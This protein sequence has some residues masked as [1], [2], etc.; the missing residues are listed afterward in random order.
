MGTMRQRDEDL[1]EHDATSTSLGDQVNRKILAVAEDS[2]TGFFRDPVG[3]I[4]ARSD[5]PADIVIE[6]LRAL[7]GAGVVRRVRQT[8]I[9][10]NLAEGALVAWRVPEER[11]GDAFEMMSER[12]PFTGHVV[13]R[14]AETPGPGTDYRLWTTVKVPRGF[15]PDKHCQ[16]LREHTGADV[17]RMMP[18]LA[19]F[20]LGVGHI[21]R[22]EIAP[23]TRADEPAGSV[24]PEQAELSER[25]WEVLL[26]LKRE[27]RPEEIIRDI[28]TPR[29]KAAGLDVGEFCEIAESLADRNVIGRFSAFLEHSKQVGDGTPASRH[30]ALVQWAVPEGRELEAGGEIGRHQVLTH[31]YWREGGPEFGNLNIMGVI[32]G[33]ERE[34][35]LAHKAAIDD[36]LRDCGFVVSHSAVLWSVRA[37]IKPSEIDPGVY[38]AWCREMGREAQEFRI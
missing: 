38:E 4:A 28:W 33:L 3:E 25:E 14:Q 12:D 20:V 27:F 32:H 36:H 19:V 10:H 15:S 17:Y 22:Q 13:V 7:L 6:R 37:E 21:R 8:L 1:I 30:S 18:A 16:F 5:V 24:R 2:L 31:C 29:A 11:L 34:K 9:T 26:A 35:V 23:G